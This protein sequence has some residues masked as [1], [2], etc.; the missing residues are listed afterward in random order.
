MYAKEVMSGIETLVTEVRK[1]LQEGAVNIGGTVSLIGKPVPETGYMVGGYTDSLILDSGLV[2]HSSVMESMLLQ[3]V[4]NEFAFATKYS[5]FLG[6]WL[7]REDDLLYFDFSQHFENIDDARA[8]AVFNDEIA[9]WD[10]ANAEEIRVK[11]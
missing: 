2:F 6:A 3:F 8:A 10:L 1:Q 11:E 5:T 7:D 4:S 9:I